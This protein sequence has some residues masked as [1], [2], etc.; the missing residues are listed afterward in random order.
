MLTV[1]FGQKENPLILGSISLNCYVLKDNKRV[2]T[3]SSIQKAL[4]YDGKSENWVTEFIDKLNGFFFINPE[5]SSAFKNAIIVKITDPKSKTTT[6]ENTV[7]SHYFIELCKIIVKAKEDGFLNITQL[8]HAKLALLALKAV[9][10]STIEDLI[11]KVTGFTRY[12]I[13]TLEHFSTLIK[14]QHNDTIFDWVKTFP[15]AFIENILTMHSFFWEDIQKQPALVLELLNEI[16]F[17]RIENDV[18][19]AIRKSKPKRTYTRKNNKKQEIEHPNLK[20]FILILI[21][22]LKASG[23]N[24]NIFIQLLNKAYPKQKNATKIIYIEN[25]E[26]ITP[27]SDFNEKLKT[28]IFK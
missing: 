4:G 14:K 7:E 18:L 1:R 8:K 19:E 13:V 27:Y 21:S 6:F 11:D 22:L 23:N 28:V 25:K 24:W 20:E 2:L 12:K 3:I 17:S 15:L 16:I 9:E 26:G 10:L 5:L